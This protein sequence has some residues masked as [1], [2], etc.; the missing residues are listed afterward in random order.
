MLKSIKKYCN[1]N[2]KKVTFIILAGIVVVFLYV[3]MFAPLLS[4]ALSLKELPKKIKP[5]K[6]A[7]MTQDLDALIFELEYFREDLEMLDKNT[8]KISIFSFLP[9]FG[10]YAKDAK[11][12]SSLSLDILDTSTELLGSLEGSIPNLDFK[13]WGSSEDFLAETAGVTDMVKISSVLSAKLPEYEERFRLI[14]KKVNSIYIDKYPEE[15][16]G[17]K[18]KATLENLKA[19]SYVLSSSFDDVVKLLEIAPELIGD[20]EARNYLIFL[21]NDKELRPSGGVLTAYAVFTLSKGNLKVTK[22]GDVVFLEGAGNA[23]RY[24]DPPA[25]IRT[26]LNANRFYIK[27]ASFSPDFRVSSL[28]IKDLW[29][30]TLGTFPVHGIIGVDTHFVA[31]LLE[32]T[33]GIDI[34]G[35]GEVNSENV[36]DQLEL[37][38]VLA[39]SHE[40][41][42]QKNLTSALL[43]ELMRKIFITGPS[44]RMELIKKVLQEANEKHILVY[45]FSEEAQ[46]ILEKYNFAG[47]VKEVDGDYIYIVDSNVGRDRANWYVNENITK[48]VDLSVKD[49]PT[50][51]VTIE[52]DNTGEY[53]ET[54]NKLYKD[55]I[56]IYVPKGSKLISSEGLLGVGQSDDL[57]KTFFEG[58]LE[59]APK[60]KAK[61]TVEYELPADI[62]KDNYR[63]LVQKQPGKGIFPYKVQ[64]GSNSKEFNLDTDKE[65]FIDL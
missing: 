56:R 33:G 9:Y 2:K 30:K 45:L 64:I 55:Y 52:Y 12:I 63:L 40:D 49:N 18:V 29:G 54:Y 13:G 34:S 5:I 24:T 21:Q 23:I 59:V 4:I 51:L 11:T 44:E 31:S 60:A 16:K 37:F 57:G 47:A 35:Y 26:Y 42:D 62:V 32:V 50:S 14:N 10:T 38:S 28:Q 27:D 1:K 36:V 25:Y 19:I 46:K 41:K 8:S 17:I 15:F 43:Y 61:I 6:V 7:A 48:T 65:I 3:F 22:S 53:H 39:G 20:K 58:Y